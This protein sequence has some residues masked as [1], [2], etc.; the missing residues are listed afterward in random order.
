MADNIKIVG[1]ILNIDTISR[2][3]PEDINLINSKKL[4]ENFGGK[5]DYIEY[6]VYTYYN[7]SEFS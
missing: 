7:V 5:D 4:Q 1:D 3:L 2:Y 6:F